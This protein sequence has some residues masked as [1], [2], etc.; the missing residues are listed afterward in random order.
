MASESENTTSYFV[1]HLVDQVFDLYRSKAESNSLTKEERGQ[2]FYD[3]S[4]LLGQE[5]VLR[6]LH[7]LDDHNFSF[8]HAKNNRSVCVVEISKGTEY[9]RLIPSVN[10]CKCEFFQCHVL[11]LPR[12]ILYQDVPSGQPGILEDW[13]EESRVSYTCQHILA[14]RLH[15][16]LK[17]TGRKTTEKILKKEDIK[18]LQTDVFRD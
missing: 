14:L 10:F 11:Q 7:L 12:G 2:F 13:S 17:H 3:L 9:F 8:F 16:F 5:L 18:E 4:I 6:S 1:P 15:Q